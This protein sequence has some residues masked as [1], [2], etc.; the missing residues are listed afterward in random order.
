M[1]KERILIAVKTYPTLSQKYIEL[2]CTAGFREDGSWIRLYPS[3]FRFLENDQKYSKYQW[4]EADIDKNPRDSRPESYRPIN[5]D[6]IRLGDKLPTHGDWQQRKDFIFKNN[7]IFTNLAT[8]IQ[9]AKDNTFSLAIF[10]PSKIKDFIVT[11]TEREWKV[12]RQQAAEASLKQGSLFDDTEKPDY[13]LVPK[14]PYKFS[15]KFV[16]DVGKE[17]TLMIEDWEIGQLYWNCLKKYDEKEAVQKVKEKYFDTFA[18][19]KDLYL[20]LGTTYEHH[21]KKARNPYVIIGTFHPP[22]EPKE[23]QLSLL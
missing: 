8:V 5:I 2:V 20:F 23:K 9:G 6:D 18:K 21:M 4:I 7:T 14:L 19:T 13:K 11:P 10:K 15:Y 22:F 3:P 16:D 17:S 12:A 1:P